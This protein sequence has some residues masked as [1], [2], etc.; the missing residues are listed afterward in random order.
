MA[1]IEMRQNII[2]NQQNEKMH[3][4]LNLQGE[5]EVLEL[6]SSILLKI[7]LFHQ[8]FIHIPD[9]KHSNYEVN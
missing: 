9:L 2:K 1:E 3:I 8:F 7:I 6:I 5:Q 4:K